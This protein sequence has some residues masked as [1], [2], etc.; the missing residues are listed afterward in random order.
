[1]YRFYKIILIP[2]IGS[3]QYY[4]N[5]YSLYNEMKNKV[6]NREYMLG[7]FY[8]QECLILFVNY[9]LLKPNFVKK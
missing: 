4:I 6:R 1:M 8:S 9:V 5:Q 2:I 7:Y 3:G